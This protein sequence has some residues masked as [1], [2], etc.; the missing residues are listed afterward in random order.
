MGC[1]PE[2]RDVVK[3][4]LLELDAG[5]EVRL[6]VV[7]GRKQQEHNNPLQ[8]LCYFVSEFNSKKIKI[9]F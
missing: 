8:H 4:L 7:E 9:I 5:K 1:A 3:A 6:L 2:V